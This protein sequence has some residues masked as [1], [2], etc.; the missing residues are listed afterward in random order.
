MSLAFKFNCMLH[1]PQWNP[2]NTALVQYLKL[3]E[4]FFPL[5]TVP[6]TYATVF[7]FHVGTV[8]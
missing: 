7:K 2:S 6:G 3:S 5:L 1:V 8:H 4:M